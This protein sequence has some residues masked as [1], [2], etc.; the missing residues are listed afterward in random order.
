MT[1]RFDAQGEERRCLMNV[2]RQAVQF[3][4]PMLITTM[5]MRRRRSRRMMLMMTMTMIMWGKL[6]QN[7]GFFVVHLNSTL[8]S[9]QQQSMFWK[10]RGNSGLSVQRQSSMEQKWNNNWQGNAEIDEKKN[11]QTCQLY[12]TNV[13]CPAVCFKPRVLPLCLDYSPD[14]K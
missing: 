7:A 3:F 13:L 10:H 8:Y 12:T 2:Y 5:M 6:L 1:T 4:V 9:S 14:I 11:E